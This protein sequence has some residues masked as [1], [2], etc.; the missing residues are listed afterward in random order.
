[1]VMG[2]QNERLLV[3]DRIVVRICDRIVAVAVTGREQTKV[4]ATVL[5]LRSRKAS[6][7]S[8]WVFGFA[9]ATLGV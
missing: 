1:M 5:T 9:S 3:T 4:S 2:N 8:G 7:G 6:L